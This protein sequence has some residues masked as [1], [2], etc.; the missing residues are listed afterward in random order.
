MEDLAKALHEVRKKKGD[1]VKEE[2]ALIAQVHE[3][4][5]EHD[6]SEV[7]AGDYVLRRGRA[8]LKLTCDDVA[9]VPEDFTQVKVDR[10]KVKSHFHET[11]EIVRGCNMETAPGQLK[12]SRAKE[13]EE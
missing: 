7:P 3:A 11:G 5:D 13:Q 8:E 10:A 12:F 9:L 6:L 4:M 1:L 2:K